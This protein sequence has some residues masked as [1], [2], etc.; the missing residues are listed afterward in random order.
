[1]P[2]PAASSTAATFS[3]VRVVWRWIDPPTMPRVAGS[4]G[5]WPDT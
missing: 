5:S 4:S 2:L 3:S 1:M